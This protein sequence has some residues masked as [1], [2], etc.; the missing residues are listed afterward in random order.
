VCACLLL[1]LL[2]LLAAHMSGLK[3]VDRGILDHVAEHVIEI[4][5]HQP[6]SALTGLVAGL[7]GSHERADGVVRRRQQAGTLSPLVLSFGEPLRIEALSDGEGAGRAYRSF[8][9]GMMQGYAST[10]FEESQD[11]VQ[12]YLTPH[13]AYQ[14]LRAPI[15]GHVAA[16]EDLGRP[17]STL[18]RVLPEQLHSARTWRERFKLVEEALLRLAAAGREPDDVVT[19]MSTAIHDSGGRARIA[20]LIRRTGFSHRHVTTRFCDQLGLTPKQM[21]G[22]VRFERA[23]AELGTAPLAELAARHGYADQ[24][25]LTR[26]VLRYAGESPLA[27]SRAHR[28]TAHT[29][30][31][32]DPPA[33]DLRQPSSKAPTVSHA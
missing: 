8:V 26:D 12:V 18:C 30:L 27:L 9:A 24:S 25:H 6:H 14:L 28:P 4:V 15:G 13:G 2:I 29:A 33:S 20:D 11:G 31:G 21:A 22:V 10:M 5:R 19:W 16:L 3:K 1:L 7:V 17:A 23:S 32:I